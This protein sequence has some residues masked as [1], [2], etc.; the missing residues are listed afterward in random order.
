[1]QAPQD[2]AAQAS[3]AGSG[4]AVRVARESHATRVFAG[5]VRQR[6]VPVA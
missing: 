1:M 5:F 3:A 4:I 6:A 2:K